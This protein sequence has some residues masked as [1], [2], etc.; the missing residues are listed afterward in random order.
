MCVFSYLSPN[1]LQHTHNNED[2]KMYIGFNN[3]AH[4]VG[5]LMQQ[6]KKNNTKKTLQLR[7][8]P[9]IVLKKNYF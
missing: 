8:C 2:I 7:K 1:S 5:K 4:L 3:N 9:N 6:Q